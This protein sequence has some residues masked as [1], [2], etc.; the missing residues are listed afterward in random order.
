[1]RTTLDCLPCFLK[2]ALYTARLCTADQ[3]H[4]R[5]IITRI[6]ALLDELD[7]ALTPPENSIAI[8]REIRSLTGCADPFVD[9]KQKSN[10]FA[11]QVRPQVKKSIAAATDPLRAASLFAIAGNIIDYGA[12]HDFDIN[13]TLDGCLQKQLHLDD[14]PLFRRDISQASNILYLGDNCGELVF[15]GLLMEALQEMGIS[16]TLAVK[17][18]PI[19]NDALVADARDCGLERCSRV[20]SNGTDCPGT[21]LALCSDEFRTAFA[22]ADLIISKGQ[23]HFETLSETKAPIYFLLTVKCPVVANHINELLGKETLHGRNEMV[24]FKSPCFTK[25][26]K[27]MGRISCPTAPNH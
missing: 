5:L 4:Q 14:Y 12:Q 7:I 6:M 10:H 19:I 9:L 13:Q 26:G 3:Q 11:L 21:P 8:Y 20:I 24:L 16:I 15:D 25:N 22:R 1:M 17:E 18:S 27:Q 2:Q 23:G